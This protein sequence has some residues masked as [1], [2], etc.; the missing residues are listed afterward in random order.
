M[1]T[2]P[3][4]DDTT[5]GA[6]LGNADLSALGDAAALALAAA[7]GQISPASRAAGVDVDGC[8][9]SLFESAILCAV[10]CPA[11]CAMSG[12]ARS[13][14]L[15]QMY[16]GC[17]LF[18]CVHIDLRHRRV[19]YSR[20]V[21]LALVCPTTHVAVLHVL[22]AAGLPGA[23]SGEADFLANLDNL[24]NLSSRAGGC[25]GRGYVTNV[26]VG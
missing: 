2:L 19:T 22:A 14:F 21:S 8:G 18:G 16:R 1:G 20:Y 26:A 24:V 9:E 23:A 25:R 13:Q 15:M 12:V 7:A 11:C 10:A 3:R 4:A 17:H 6:Y 5:L